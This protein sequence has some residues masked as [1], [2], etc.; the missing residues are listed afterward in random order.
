MR[1][2]FE[3]IRGEEEREKRREGGERKG[4]PALRGARGKSREVYE[5]KYKRKKR[6]S[7]DTRGGVEDIIVIREASGPF[8]EGADCEREKNINVSIGLDEQLRLQF[9]SEEEQVRCHLKFQGEGIPQHGTPT[10]E[11]LSSHGRKFRWNNCG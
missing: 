4:Y 1:C 3:S 10:L 2:N 11:S 7:G 9:F 5:K 6:N 8:N